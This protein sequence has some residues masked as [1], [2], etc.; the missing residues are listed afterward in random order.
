M[1]ILIACVD[2]ENGIS[3]NGK[4]PWVLKP[5]ISRFCEKTMNAVIIM[6]PNTWQRIGGRPLL[7]RTNIVVTPDPS[8]INNGLVCRTLTDAMDI[9]IRLLR[10]IYII[11]GEQ[12]FEQGLSYASTVYITRINQ[13]FDCDEFFPMKSMRYKSSRFQ[14]W[15]INEDMIYRFETYTI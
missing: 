2:V 10:P 13:S 5:D 11:G 6:G 7:N 3:K 9:A 15:K 1:V 12:L 8:S 14:D 4:V